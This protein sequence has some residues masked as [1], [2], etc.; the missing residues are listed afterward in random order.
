MDF[1]KTA[2]TIK[3]TAAEKQ[4]V[5]AAQDRLAK[6]HTII[7][8]YGT[9][10]LQGE[11][12][13]A[14][15]RIAELGEKFKAEPTPELA[16]EI[17]QQVILHANANAISLHLGGHTENLRTAISKELEPLA[18]ELTKRTIAALDEQLAT[19]ITGLE[20]IGG[21]EDSIAE[22]RTRHARQ[23]EIGNHDCGELCEAWRDS[24]MFILHTF[25]L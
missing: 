22:L 20:K 19:A 16:A 14:Q 17:A 3:L 9:E 10:G 6:A 1:Y 21:L 5:K 11:P 15:N 18:R 23:C 4:Q 7:A 13:P 24:R 12:S 2:S 8:A 25:T